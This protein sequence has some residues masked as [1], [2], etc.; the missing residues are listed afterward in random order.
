MVA[1]YL[2]WNVYHIARWRV[3]PSI[4]TATTGFPSPT[5]GGT[6]SLQAL[7]RGDLRGS[8]YYNPMTIPIL[9]L[10]AFTI[11]LAVRGGH[12]G[13]RLSW[14]W[15]GILLLAWVVKLLSPTSTW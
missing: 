13:K 2:V 1:F 12:A 7:M 4:L 5:T 14:V 8:L 15:V 3:P 9:G 6:R 11:C 10:T